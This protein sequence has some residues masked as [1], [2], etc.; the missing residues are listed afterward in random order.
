MK[1]IWTM[2]AMV[3]VFAGCSQED[4][5]SPINVY[6]L[7]GYANVGSRTA[8][9]SPGT[10]S[11]PFQWSAGDYIYNGTNKSNVLSN[12]GSSAT[13]TF[14][15]TSSFSEVYY[16]ISGSSAKQ[17]NVQTAQTV[18]NLG[19]NG[20]FGYG[21]VSDGTFRLDHAT[22]Y[23]W[24]DVTSSLSN[25]TLQSIKVSADV[26]I[27]GKA[28]CN[29]S[30]F[31]TE[32][33]GN[34]AIELTVNQPL[35]STN[36]NVWAMV[37]LP[38]LA[39]QSFKVTYKLKVGNNTKY[40]SHTVTGKSNFTSGK[41]QKVSMNITNSTELTDYAELRILTFEDE[42]AKF[43]EYGF[44][45]GDGEYYKIKT[46]SDLIPEEQWYSGSP[47]IY[48]MSNDA[49]YEWYDENN[50]GLYHIF[51]LNYDIRNYAGGGAAISSHTVELD[52]LNEYSIYD[53]QVSVT[54]GSGNN[55]S[56]NFCVAYNVSEVNPENS[57]LEKTTLVFGDGEA[58]VIDHM[59]VTIAAPTHYCIKYGNSFSQAYDDDDFLKLVATGIKEDD[60]ETEPIEILLAEG[61]DY[62]ITD[63]TKW[64]LSGLGEVVGVKFH[65]EEAQFDTYSGVSYYRTPLYFA[66]DDI[67]VR[68]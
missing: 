64:D 40:C 9:G 5:D 65:M 59:Y 48:Y 28:T 62:L 31:G 10:T 33:E 60:S 56:D 37:V 41:T 18:G 45:G 21:T 20:D 2:M 58:H 19:T 57:G 42:D 30:S 43:E 49:E 53:Y 7:T 47:L 68:F 35:S 17:A 11:I 46:W 34:K 29:G 15:G 50:T 55:G 8:F 12:G 52:E 44:T 39:S 54:C 3:L 66:F 23:L 24:F 25:V 22:S 38:K 32:S 14:S 36:S 51:P 13:F 6:S 27:A 26:N 16:N 4:T 63:W 67:A 1:K 61:S